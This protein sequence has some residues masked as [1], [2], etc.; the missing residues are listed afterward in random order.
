MTMDP[1]QKI[2]QFKQM[3]DADPGN[4]LGHFSFAKA[5]FEAGRYDEAIKPFT[6]AIELRETMSKAYQLLGETFEKLAGVGGFVA[7][8]VGES[9][10][11]FEGSH[12]CAVL[13]QFCHDL[14]M[15]RAI[16]FSQRRTRRSR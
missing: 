9:Q 4:E 10:R 5:L 11:E 14:S 6:R 8:E 16:L 13:Q 12:L 15:G 7:L 1:E 2:Q 3:A